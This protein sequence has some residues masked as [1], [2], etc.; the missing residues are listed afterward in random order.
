MNKAKTDFR[1]RRRYVRLKTP[2]EIAYFSGDEGKVY[3]AVAE[4]ISAD[5]LRFQTEG[6]GMAEGDSLELK[7]CMAG[8][9]NPVHA[10]AKVVWMKRVSLEDKSPFDV[11]LEFTSVEEDNKNTFLKNLCDLMYGISENRGKGKN[12]CSG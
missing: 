5:G 7:L 8:A 3:K 6:R 2:V 11:G 10:R 12:R 4:N 1:E 9:A